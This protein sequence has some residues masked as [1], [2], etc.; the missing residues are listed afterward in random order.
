MADELYRPN[1]NYKKDYLDKVGGLISSNGPIEEI[2]FEYLTEALAAL[3]I[4]E[5]PYASYPPSDQGK[6]NID[7][8]LKTS[9]EKI[10]TEPISNDRT[11]RL[12]RLWDYLAESD[13]LESADLIYVFGG[14]GKLSVLEGIRL[15]KENYAPKIMF[16]GNKPSYAG[17]VPTTEAEEYK[18]LAMEEG[19]DEAVILIEKESI[20]TPENIVNSAKIL[21]SLG[22]LPKKI[23]AV[24]I[25]Y[26]MRRASLTMRAGFDWNYQLIR[27]AGPSTKYSRENYFMDEK[28]WSYVFYEYLKMY[29]AREMGHF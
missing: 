27:H 7:A 1:L 4:T 11:E 21:H 13:S 8:I 10:T 25:A 26:H 6:E 17:E 29:G 2:H 12:H 22:P 16:S 20:N 14:I 9:F 18:A 5:D 24:S 28:G 19:V 15:K 23:I 3:D